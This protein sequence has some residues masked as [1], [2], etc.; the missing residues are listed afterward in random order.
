MLGL[1]RLLAK[2]IGE[3]RVIIMSI[4]LSMVPGILRWAIDPPI[5]IWLLFL[6]FNTIAL[7]LGDALFVQFATLYTTPKNRGTLMGLFQIGN[8]VGRFGGAL[9]A[10]ELYN[11][12]WRNG[13]LLFM[14]YGSVSLIFLCFVRPLLEQNVA[15]QLEQ[16]Q[17]EERATLARV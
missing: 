17:K 8:S 10:G 16:K 11:W 13:S 14:L 9:M 6:P 1:T 12:N 4:I 7:N 3:L 2:W 5:P 15:D